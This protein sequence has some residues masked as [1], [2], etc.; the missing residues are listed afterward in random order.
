MGKTFRPHIRDKFV[1][2]SCPFCQSKDIRYK[3]TV[4]HDDMMIQP[5]YC[6]DCR[7]SWG[8]NYKYLYSILEEEPDE[9]QEIS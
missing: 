8:D 6:G 3:L 4:T 2:N 9:S 1:S 5:A 7:A